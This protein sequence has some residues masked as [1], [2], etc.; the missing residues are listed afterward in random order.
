MIDAEIS[1]LRMAAISFSN[2]G[3]CP[4][5]AN[6][7]SKQLTWTGSRPPYASFALDLIYSIKSNTRRW[8]YAAKIYRQ[9]QNACL[10]CC[11]TRFNRTRRGNITLTVYPVILLPAARNTR[12]MPP[13]SGVGRLMTRK[14][15]SLKRESPIIP[16]RRARA[17]D[18]I[19][20][21][22]R[23]QGVQDHE[24]GGLNILSEKFILHNAK[25]W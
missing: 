14:R 7:S 3:I 22:L 4:I 17:F 10:H 15:R 12:T 8:Y 20:T 18:S 23:K 5:F 2:F 1:R 13:L 6:L 16:T 25:P 11:R 24:Q 9:T 21:T 19:D